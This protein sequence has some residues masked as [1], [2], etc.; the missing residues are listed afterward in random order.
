MTNKLQFTVKSQPP[1]DLRAQPGRQLSNTFAAPGQR[2]L[3]KIILRIGDKL[4][5]HVRVLYMMQ[6]RYENSCLSPEG[7]GKY[8]LG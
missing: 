7:N 5:A 4:H 1:V 3:H 8:S 6:H 2:G